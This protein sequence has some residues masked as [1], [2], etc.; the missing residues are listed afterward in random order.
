MAT[1]VNDLLAGARRQGSREVSV[2]SDVLP[3]HCMQPVQDV[4]AEIADVGAVTTRPDGQ[5]L[6]RLSHVCDF[7]KLILGTD[8]GRE[9]CITSWRKLAEQGNASPEFVKCHA[10]LEYAGATIEVSHTLIAMLIAGQFHA[11]EVSPDAEHLRI[12]ELASD[13]SIDEGLLAKAAES[14]PVLDQRRASQLARW[15]E[16]VASTFEQISAER[17]D[18]MSRLRQIAE[19][20]VLEESTVPA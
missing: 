14:I 9:A 18:L 17:A 1:E 2:S 11:G 8:T 15:L 5:P 4:F 3:L 12:R 13:Y 7:C 16:D 19:M 20:S 10:G 6:T